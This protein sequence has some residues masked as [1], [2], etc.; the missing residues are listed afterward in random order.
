MSA[1]HVLFIAIVA[2]GVYWA[3]ILA[4]WA[5]VFQ[6]TYNNSPGQ[7]AVLRSIEYGAEDMESLP[8]GLVFIS[9]GLWMEDTELYRSRPGRIYLF[10]FNVPNAPPLALKIV[11][12]PNYKLIS[13]LGLSSWIDP[14]TGA[15]YLYV[16]SHQPTM[17]VDKFKFDQTKR[18]L[19]LMRRINDPKFNKLSD[20]AVVGEDQFFF[21]NHYTI[22]LY[23]ES[24]LGVPFGG[25]GY[26]DGMVSTLIEKRLSAPNGLFVSRDRKFL[27]V[28]Q[29]GKDNIRIYKLQKDSTLTFSHA[30]EVH[31]KVDNLFVDSKTGDLWLASHP[32]LFRLIRYIHGLI[33]ISPSQVMR[34]KL[35]ADSQVVKLEEIYSND[36]TEISAAAVAV[37]HGNRLLI[38]SILSNA[39]YCEMK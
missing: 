1:K 17:N 20:I 14:K 3:A 35:N 2:A 27:Y 5:G 22:S 28:A 18:T 33:K 25:L 10:D 19:T 8:N 6:R 37:V 7:C 4:D 12:D 29:S 16:I 23:L 21:T 34:V 13:P 24:F 36:G 31:T 32:S 9:S 39:V 15:V 38:G 11:A 26:Y 30:I